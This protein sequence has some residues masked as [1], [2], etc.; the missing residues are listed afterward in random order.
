M[1]PDRNIGAYLD[2]SA[3]NFGRSLL[4]F[5]VGTYLLY[6]YTDVLL[7]PLEL[8]SLLLLLCRFLDGAIDPFIGFHMDRRHN[9]FGKYRGYIILWCIPACVLHAAL[10]SPP[11]LTGTALIIYCFVVY[12]L[13]AVS[14]SIIECAHN[15]MLIT[16]S[17]NPNRRSTANTVK[18]SMGILAVMAASYL[19][20]ILVE[21]IG[22]GSERRGFALTMLIFAA[23][24]LGTIF[25]GALRLKEYNITSD[26]SLSPKQTLAVLMR[27]KKVLL[28]FAMY[29][30]SQIGNSAKSQATVYYMKYNLDR[31]DLIAIVMLIGVLSS[32][33]MQ[34]LIVVAANR[35]KVI[36]L[37]LAGYT[38]SC[39]AMAVVGLSG[40]SLPIFIAGHIL[41]GM[42]S[43]FPG[44]LIHVYMAELAEGLSG[45]HS[46]GG[47]IV[48]L[49]SV[50]ARIGQSL[51]GAAIAG[52][53][54]FSDY[55]P[56]TAQ[57]SKALT[58]IWVCLFGLTFLPYLMAAVTANASRRLAKKSV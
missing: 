25:P 4:T 1:K 17:G 47:V 41:F 29:L 42:A 46:F 32:F 11:R 38:G 15:P 33:L 51:S 31:S 6:F 37:M 26:N 40:P 28:L 54:Y 14:Y 7:L 19:P 50:S 5:T 35:H 13:W 43:A 8:V 12:L 53:L 22:G 49:L 16:I 44:N 34:P 3:I 39:L 9:R 56:N 30:C 57:N 45:E 18:I 21:K 36:T 55:T 27:N 10:F 48:S 23:V 2:Y 24:A 20:L 52:V 58:G